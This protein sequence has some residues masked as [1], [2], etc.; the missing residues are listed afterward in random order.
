MFPFWTPGVRKHTVLTE[1]LVCSFYFKRF[2]RLLN[3]T[4]QAHTASACEEKLSVVPTATASAPLQQGYRKEK[5]QRLLSPVE[6]I[7]AIF[8]LRRQTPFLQRLLRDGTTAENSA[9][10]RP[11]LSYPSPGRL[12][13]SFMTITLLFVHRCS[14]SPNDSRRGNEAV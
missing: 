6:P 1:R 4:Q 12:L 5:K 14:V 11:S 3:P 7:S 2:A 9:V 8:L 13:Q 10:S